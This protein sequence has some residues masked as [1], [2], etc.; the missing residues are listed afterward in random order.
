MV[1]RDCKVSGR[2][3]GVAVSRS[4]G[5]KMGVGVKEQTFWAKEIFLVL[6]IRNEVDQSHLPRLDDG[7]ASQ[8]SSSCT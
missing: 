5:G 6:G 4:R 7:W 8:S 1:L 2:S 3:M